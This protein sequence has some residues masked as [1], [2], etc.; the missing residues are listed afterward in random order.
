MDH[1]ATSH[2]ETSRRIH[3]STGWIKSVKCNSWS[4]ST[5]RPPG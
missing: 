2:D 4:A 1:P 5:W 3:F